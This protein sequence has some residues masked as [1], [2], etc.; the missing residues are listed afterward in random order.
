MKMKC[1]NE[2]NIMNCELCNYLMFNVQ[3]Q[4]LNYFLCIK[5]NNL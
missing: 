5:S 1:E 2:L 3:V 4:Y